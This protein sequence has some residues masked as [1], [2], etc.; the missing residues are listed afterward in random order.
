MYTELLLG[1]GVTDSG[2]KAAGA[3]IG[4]G[5]AIAGGA[6]GAALGDAQVGA[7]TISGIAR[8]PEAQTRLYTTMFLIVGLCEAAYFINVAFMAMFVFVLSR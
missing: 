7:A 1:Q 5:L 2:L 4:G 3:L 8:Q 6:I